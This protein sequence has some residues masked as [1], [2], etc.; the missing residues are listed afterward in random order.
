MSVT[1]SLNRASLPSA[2]ASAAPRAAETSRAF[3]V[4]LTTGETFFTT[5]F[6]GVLLARLIRAPFMREAVTADVYHKR[7][8]GSIARGADRYRSGLAI[9]F[10]RSRFLHANSR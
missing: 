1:I 7:L 9:S 2:G 3:E 4:C 8:A 5:G 6:A 10:M